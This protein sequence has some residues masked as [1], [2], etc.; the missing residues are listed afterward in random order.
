[1]ADKLDLYGGNWAVT[2]A[3][4]PNKL[5]LAIQRGLNPSARGCELE[6]HPVEPAFY[7][8]WNGR[9]GSL[10]ELMDAG[11]K[12]PRRVSG[13]EDGLQG[14]PE[15]PETA[16]QALALSLMADWHLEG[17]AR[18][19]QMLSWL[20][21]GGLEAS[22]RNA[23]GEDALKM[24]I[25]RRAVKLAAMLLD[26]GAR[27]ED[28]NGRGRSAFDELDEA[29]AIERAEAPTGEEALAKFAALRAKMTAEREAMEIERV[30]SESGPTPER[31]RL[32]V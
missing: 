20:C 31:A 28:R 2:L 16:L 19:P 30:V 21:S 23:K 18:A 29:V 5:R 10:I 22:E 17:H 6:S 11:V 3:E 1:M 27:P 25:R 32:R 14:E 26:A 8:A 24:A 9:V 13:L 12:P 4:S 15:S 7:C